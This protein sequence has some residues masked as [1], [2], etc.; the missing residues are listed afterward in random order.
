[1]NLILEHIKS[2]LNK[3]MNYMGIACGKPGTGKSYAVISIAEKVDNKF[4]ADKIAFTPEEFLEII[5][6]P[7]LKSGSAVVF[8]EVGVGIS[9]RDWYSVSN[10]LVNAVFQTFR[11]RQ[12]VVFFNT[13]NL[14]YIDSNS[15][16]LFHGYLEPV[17]IDFNTEICTAKYMEMQV[18][19]RDTRR[20]IYYH[21]LRQANKP[22][23]RHM[24]PKPSVEILE[25]YEKKKGEF[26]QSLIDNALKELEELRAG[27]KIK[28]Q[29]G[30]E[31]ICPVCNWKWR[32]KREKLRFQCPGCRGWFKNP[33]A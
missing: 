10:K 32:P 17:H 7:K 26:A 13:P 29:E 16:V 12:L 9:A 20:K 14:L 11:L 1:M 3:R 5:K 15:R 31:T 33:R 8:E 30:Y 25:A 28:E 19:P 27:K 21:Y 4:D 18:N 24:I 23:T 6:N 22:I 2:N